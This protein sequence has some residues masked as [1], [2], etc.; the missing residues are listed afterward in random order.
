MAGSNLLV[1]NTICYNIKF[2]QMTVKKVAS[3]SESQIRWVSNDNVG[4]NIPYF[5]IKKHVVGTH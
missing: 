4:D 5:S 2:N 3:L 1:N